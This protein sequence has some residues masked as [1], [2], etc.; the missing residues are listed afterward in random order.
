MHDLGAKLEDLLRRQ[1]HAYARFRDLL[2]A[3]HRALT[4][5]DRA[6]LE[7]CIG[8]RSYL[9]AE[10]EALDQSFADLL[11][12][13]GVAVSP[14][15]VRKLLDRLPRRGD[16]APSD[17]WRQLL[18]VAAECRDQNALNGRI[19]DLNRQQT[20]RVLRLLTGNGGGSAT[21]AADGKVAHQKTPATLATA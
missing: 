5:R 11:R 6:A 20:E 9:V 21:Y 4:R 1:L 10:L 18:T 3:E 7:Q 8:E 12:R 15:A 16:P 2:H 17:L 19:I 13:H 14:A